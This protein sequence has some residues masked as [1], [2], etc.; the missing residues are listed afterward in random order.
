MLEQLVKECEMDLK[1]IPRGVFIIKIVLGDLGKGLSST[2]HDFS[3]P[4]INS[5]SVPE[6]DCVPLS[7][8]NP[9]ARCLWSKLSAR[10]PATW[11]KGLKAFNLLIHRVA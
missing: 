9:K 6:I 2:E 11:P 3:S 8:T 4:L 5:F 1:S 7:S 10:D